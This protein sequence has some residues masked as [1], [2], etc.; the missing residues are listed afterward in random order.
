MP[1]DQCPENYPSGSGTMTLDRVREESPHVL[2]RLPLDSWEFVGIWYLEF[3]HSRPHS[4][5][6]RSPPSRHR[7]PRATPAV[8]A[9]PFAA[10][11]LLAAHRADRHLLHLLLTRLRLADRHCFEFQPA[12]QPTPLLDRL[13]HLDRPAA[14]RTFRTFPR[15]KRAALWTD[16]LAL[17]GR[18]HC[19]SIQTTPLK[20][21]ANAVLARA[22]IKTVL[23]GFFALPVVKIN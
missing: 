7:P 18:H 23:L 3:G 8:P 6:Q 16:P 20:R 13:H 14:I 5:K 19:R 9:T 11:H 1:N 22:T 12:A 2:N 4:S 17:S 21:K 15:D 10:L